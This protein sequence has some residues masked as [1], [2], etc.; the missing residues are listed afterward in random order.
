MPW[1]F[2]KSNFFQKLENKFNSLVF[3]YWHNKI[4]RYSI[5]RVWLRVAISW[6]RA[7]IFIGAS[8]SND[9]SMAGWILSPPYKKGGVLYPRRVL[10]H[11]STSTKSEKKSCPEKTKVQS[12]LIRLLVVSSQAGCIYHSNSSLSWP[13]FVPLLQVYNSKCCHFFT[14][15][16]PPLHL[17]KFSSKVSYIQGA[18][19]V[20]MISTRALHC[21]N[22]CQNLRLHQWLV[23]SIGT[24]LGFRIK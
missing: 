22:N 16:W 9:S 15:R 13:E 1:V 6:F 18:I 5:M 24:Y 17:G 8:A 14:L 10:F 12:G 11:K 7:S 3:L 20:K 23:L 2:Y 19:F 4:S 21:F